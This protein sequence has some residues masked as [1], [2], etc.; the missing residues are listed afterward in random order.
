MVTVKLFGVLRLE[1]GLRELHTEAGSVRELYPLLL[2][3]IRRTR[4]DAAIGERELRACLVAV[5]GEQASPRT[6]LC[7]G[8]TV[9]LFPASA[10]G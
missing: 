1:S 8:D 3:E 7:D 2:R 5:N 6:K 9:Y 10:G 4:P